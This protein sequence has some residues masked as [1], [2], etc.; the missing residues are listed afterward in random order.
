MILE[1]TDITGNERASTHVAQKAK[2]RTKKGF[3]LTVRGGNIERERRPDEHKVFVPCEC[4]NEE[5]IIILEE[6]LSYVWLFAALFVNVIDA[7]GAWL[8]SLGRQTAEMWP[9]AEIDQPTHDLLAPEFSLFQAAM[10]LVDQI[11]PFG[12]VKT[13]LSWR[14]QSHG[15]PRRVPG[16]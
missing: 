2:P 13:F 8:N 11:A 12:K 9:D 16:M 7:L 5:G 15:K 3:A 14:Y 10:P 1:L 4:C 6:F